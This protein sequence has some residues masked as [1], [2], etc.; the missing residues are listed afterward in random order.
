MNLSSSF[1]HTNKLKLKILIIHLKSYN[2]CKN[3]V[4][5]NFCKVMSHNNLLFRIFEHLF[6]LPNYIY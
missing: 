2:I 1:R 6:K 4:Y 5:N 3:M